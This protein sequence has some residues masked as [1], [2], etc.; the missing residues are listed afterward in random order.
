MGEEKD[1]IMGESGCSTSPYGF[2]TWILQITNLIETQQEVL[3]LAAGGG[4]EIPQSA[5]SECVLSSPDSFCFLLHPFNWRMG[6]QHFANN[7]PK[8]FFKNILQKKRLKDLMGN[9]ISPSTVVCHWKETYFADVARPALSFI[10][11]FFPAPVMAC[12]GG[13]AWHRCRI[14]SP[15]WYQ[16]QL[17]LGKKLFALNY[18]V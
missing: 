15:W 2:P 6:R 10:F 1:E 4:G 18:A 8:L 7:V 11:I 14:R 5:E 16:S 12:L 9:H 3:L 17:P 13:P